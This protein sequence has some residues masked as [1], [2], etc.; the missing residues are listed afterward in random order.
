MAFASLHRVLALREEQ[1]EQLEREAEDIT[2]KQDKLIGV[3]YENVISKELFERE[4][5]RLCILLTQV[6]RK[7][8]VAIIVRTSATQRIQE[9]L[10]LL[11]DVQATYEAAT[12]RNQETT[13]SG[14]IRKNL[15]W[16][17]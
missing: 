8:A 14:D 1:V 5:Q 9:S 6:E 4:Q 15:A 11:Q 13:Q 7:L 17:R 16:L 2:E 10:E 3:Y 12:S